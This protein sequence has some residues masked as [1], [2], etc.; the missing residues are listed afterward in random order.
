MPQGRLE[1]E[2]ICAVSVTERKVSSFTRASSEFQLA[3][4]SRV[5]ANSQGFSGLFS[6]AVLNVSYGE[7]PLVFC[8]QK[9]LGLEQ[10]SHGDLFRVISR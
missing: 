10:R 7:L 9:H 1:H 2:E 8:R 3:G 4:L 6:H 5:W